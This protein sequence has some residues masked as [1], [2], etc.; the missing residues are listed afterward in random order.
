MLEEP[1]PAVNLDGFG[2][3]SIGFNVLYWHAS[4]VPAELAA[5]HD[6]VLAIHQAFAA[7]SITIAFPQ[8]VVWG[9]EPRPDRLYGGRVSEVRTPY[10]GLVEGTAD[11]ERRATAWRLPGRRRSDSD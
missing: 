5:R 8:V 10:P 11:Q 3:S 9:G 6:L 4:D 2:D 7:R 1:A